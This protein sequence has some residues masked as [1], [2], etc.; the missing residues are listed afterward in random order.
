ML[1][2]LA[3]L[4]VK[5][6]FVIFVLFCFVCC[7]LFFSCHHSPHSFVYG[8]APLLKHVFEKQM[9][10]CLTLFTVLGVVWAAF[11][12]PLAVGVAVA[13]PAP[14]EGFEA[15]SRA[16]GGCRDTEHSQ[17][18]GQLTCNAGTSLQ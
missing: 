15:A 11:S 6:G 2:K 16:G 18:L 10:E 5:L 9:E 17:A 14:L 3:N 13:L 4:F 1:E 12:V 7:F 8:T